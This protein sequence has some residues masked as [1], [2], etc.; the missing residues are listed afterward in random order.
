MDF[1]LMMLARQIKELLKWKKS[2]SHIQNFKNKDMTMDIEDK[3]LVQEIC[4]IIKQ[5]T[6]V[7]LKVLRIINLVN[8]SP[9]IRI[10]QK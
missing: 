1:L 3:I 2:K 6:K 9:E 10:D 8:P 4:L 5:E 7:I